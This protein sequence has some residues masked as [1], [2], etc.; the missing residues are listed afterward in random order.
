[1]PYVEQVPHIAVD[2]T[3]FP[4]PPIMLGRT[5]SPRD[6]E[7]LETFLRTLAEHGFDNDEVVFSGFDGGAIKQLGVNPGARQPR[8]WVMD[9]KCWRW[10]LAQAATLDTAID[11][12]ERHV[13]PCVGVY[14]LSQLRVD[15][16]YQPS[17][18]LPEIRATNNAENGIDG[19]YHQVTHTD[20]PK[21][22]PEAALQALMFFKYR[23]EPEN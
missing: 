1:M 7:F 3:G 13:V 22:L 18:G 20:Y 6:S 23:G 19:I 14:D 4:E 9:Q 5:P 8:L 21:V 11:F 15:Q 2:R 10:A 12:A 16:R 17:V